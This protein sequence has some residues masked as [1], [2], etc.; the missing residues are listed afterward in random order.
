MRSRLLVNF[1]AP[2]AAVLAF[3][4]SAP[5]ENDVPIIDSVE[6][7]SVVQAKN[8]NYEI[9]ILVTFHDNDR[10]AVTHVRYRLEG[11]SVEGTF[12]VPMPNPQRESL[13][14]TVVV[15]KEACQPLSEKSE[16]GE[17]GER[18][19]KRSRRDAD[20]GRQQRSLELTLVDAR[21]GESHPHPQL[22]ELD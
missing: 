17:R 21:G 14:F 15:A 7:P 12:D 19:E 13:W 22:V 10:E 20:S 16:K 6:A 11:T 8:G 3:G 18:S 5:E 2:A 1:L 4:C 9:P